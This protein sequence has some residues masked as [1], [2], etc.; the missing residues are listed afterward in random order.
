MHA[1]LPVLAAVCQLTGKVEGMPV[2]VEN[3]Q[4]VM[5]FVTIGQVLELVITP[6]HG[7]R[8]IFKAV[9]HAGA[10]ERFH[11]IRRGGN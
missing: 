5:R 7:A 11:A 6:D 2:V 3:R 10:I 9:R 8:N 4:Q 1:L